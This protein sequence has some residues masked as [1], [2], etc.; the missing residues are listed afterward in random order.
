MTARQLRTTAVA[1][2]E[3]LADLLQSLF[4]T[5]LIDP[6]DPI[7]IV[8]PWVSDVEVLDNRVNQLRGLLPELPPRWVRLGDVLHRL[9]MIGGR[10]VLATRGDS[11][12]LIF[13]DQLERR[14]AETGISKQLQVHLAPELH[15]KGILTKRLH[16]SGS[17]NL[18]YNGLRR[19]EESVQVSD[20]TEGLARVAH[21][22]EDRWGR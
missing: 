5:E 21:S 9:M 20:D 17:M 22:Y 18:T 4:V 19:L 11:H 13:T 10:V 8:S 14:A 3:E 6:S 7:W 2:R 16:I 15:E 1:R 12:N